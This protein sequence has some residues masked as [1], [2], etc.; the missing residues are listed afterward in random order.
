MVLF[1]FGGSQGSRTINQA[2]V[3]AL[4]LLASRAEELI[5]LHGTGAH[6]SEGYDPV[7]ETSRA[8]EA[9]GLQDYDHWYRRF[10]YI[11]EIETAYA[12]ADLVVCRAE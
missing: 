5:V 1:V 2:V 7:A 11:E 3:E 6:V 8:L 12:V 4:P 9:T 10:D